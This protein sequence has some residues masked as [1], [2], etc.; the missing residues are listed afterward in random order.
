[1]LQ[2]DVLDLPADLADRVQRRARILEDHRYLTAAKAAH[3][4]FAGLPHVDAAGEHHR[5][6]G[7]PFQAR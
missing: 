6:F 1:M 3:V 7:D 2:Q 4:V 5:T